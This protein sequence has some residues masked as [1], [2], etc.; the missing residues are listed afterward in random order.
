M[1]I[2]NK[3]TCAIIGMGRMGLRYVDI[4]KKLKLNLIAVYDPKINLLK[5]KNPKIKIDKKIIQNKLSNLFDKKPNLIIIATTSDAHFKLIVRCAQ[6]KIKYIFCEKPLTTSLSK[7]NQINEIVSNNKIFLSINHSSQFKSELI[8]CKRIA[9]SNYL[10]GITSISKIGGNMGIA[11]N[12]SHFVSDFIYLSGLMPTMV[13][14]D[15]KTDKY[16]NVRGA[17]FKDF[18]GNMTLKNKLNVKG[19]LN[20]ENDSG[21]GD[22]LILT[23]KF[24]LLILDQLS[25]LLYINKRKKKFLGDKSAFYGSPFVTTI[26]KIKISKVQ[27][28]TLTN[29]K[30]FL[31][32]KN[33]FDLRKAEVVNKTLFAAYVSSHKKN[34][35]VRIN[36]V[37]LNKDF[38][39]P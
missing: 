33:Y 8:L 37:K 11:M 12:G 2:N 32:G 3:T 22:L 16:L 30:N 18:A 31:K 38:S 7:I 29:L 24:G 26:K 20:I 5:K 14:A 34:K 10:G 13:T 39:W 4:V 27:E 19:H 23:C 28:L 6:H 25:G 35:Y 17:K 1:L 15:I 36:S 9:N 21:H